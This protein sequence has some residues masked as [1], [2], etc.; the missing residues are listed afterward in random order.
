[1]KTIQSANITQGT[2]VFVAADIDVPIENGVI[3]EPFRLDSLVPT[4]KY[5]I[6]KGGFPII[7]GH[8]AS[9]KGKFDPK[10]STTQL[11][12]YFDT[13]LGTGKYEL[14]ENL[15]FDVREEANDD[16]YAKEL[17]SKAEI[18]VN[19][20]FSTS[21][22]KQTSIVGVAKYLPSYAGLNLQREVETLS[23][24]LK[25][26][27]RPFTAIIGGA[28]LESKKPVVSTFLKVAD[29]VLIVGK[30]GMEWKEPIPENL[31]LPLDYATDSK[32][33][34]TNTIAGYKQ[35]I[36]SSK[37]I[38]W[39]GPAGLYEDDNFIVGTRELAQEIV[40]ATEQGALSVLGGGDTV[41]AVN[42]LGVLNKFSFVSTGGGAMLEFLAQGTLPGLEVL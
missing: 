34:G 30:I 26:P 23:G 8:L 36:A 18:F 22:R 41:T 32:D 27:N 37:T 9:P 42:K 11:K 20:N 24:L 28:K 17:A 7:G 31:H 1:M 15:R 35:I 10:L 12:S 5:I 19:E 29:A 39:A 3:L 40:K 25:S 2:K 38:L 33:I 6:E 13:H 4:L 21:H 14:L 16:T